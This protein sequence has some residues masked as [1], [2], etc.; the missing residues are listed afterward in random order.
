MRAHLALP[1]EDLV[2]LVALLDDELQPGLLLREVRA[3]VVEGR[4]LDDKL[5]LGRAEHAVLLDEQGLRA[6]GEGDL[7]HD[8]QHQRKEE[9]QRQDR[10][11]QPCS[12]RLLRSATRGEATRAHGEE[13]AQTSGWRTSNAVVHLHALEVAAQVGLVA[14]AQ[15][16]PGPDAQE[17]DGQRE[18]RELAREQILDRGRLPLVLRKRPPNHAP[19]HA[20]V[21]SEGRVHF[22]EGESCSGVCAWVVGVVRV[23][24]GDPPVQ[25]GVA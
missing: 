1:A 7:E 17:Q 4:A 2:E 13:R 19:T 23:A 25:A 9:P 12:H 11:R 3:E 15:Q 21:E 14:V 18:Q 16:H 5:Q 22:E 6:E 20:T 10:Q 24:G 8:A